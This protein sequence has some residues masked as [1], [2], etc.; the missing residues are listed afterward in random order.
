MDRKISARLDDDLFGWLLRYVFQ[1]DRYEA[2]SVKG[3]PMASAQLR[4]DLL[5]LRHLIQCGQQYLAGRFTKAEASCICDALNGIP[6][7]PYLVPLGSSALLGPIQEE[8]DQGLADKWRVDPGRL[9]KKIAD[10]DILDALAL[11]HQVRLVWRDD[12]KTPVERVF[13]VAG[14]TTSGAPGTSGER[15]RKK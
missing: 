10:L 4:E 14:S 11:W 15:R 1:A 13:R 3:Y 12:G 8:M 9:T 2:A 5:T 7:V 6:F